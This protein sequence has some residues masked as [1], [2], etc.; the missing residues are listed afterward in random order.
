MGVGS[1]EVQEIGATLG[2][3]VK[4]RELR[5]APQ[6]EVKEGPGILIREAHVSQG[7]MFAV[8]QSSE[9]VVFG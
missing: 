8:I 2:N 3:S 5:K 1:G 7:V 9:Q 4:V 6:A